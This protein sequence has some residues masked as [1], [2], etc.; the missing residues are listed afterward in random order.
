MSFDHYYDVLA[1]RVAH[2]HIGPDK[3]IHVQVGLAIWCGTALIGRLPLRSPIP[4]AA[5]VAAEC[6]NELLDRHYTGSWNLPDTSTDMLA[7]WFWPTLLFLLLRFEA[8]PRTPRAGG[9]TIIRR[10]R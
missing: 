5:C 6:V 8:R 3:F 2:L 7:T 4:L 10:R 1:K 9:R